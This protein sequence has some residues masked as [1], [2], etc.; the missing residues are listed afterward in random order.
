MVCAISST[1]SVRRRRSDFLQ[2]SMM[3]KKILPF[4]ATLL[5]PFL[6]QAQQAPKVGAPFLTLDQYKPIVGKYGGRLV[7]DMLGEPKSFNPITENETSSSDFTT[8]IFE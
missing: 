2:E 3:L 5:L 7:R 6:A 4:A 1:P 8:R